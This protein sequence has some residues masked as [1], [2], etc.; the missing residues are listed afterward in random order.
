MNIT[1]I[2][3]QYLENLRLFNLSVA[4]SIREELSGIGSQV[5]IDETLDIAIIYDE[6]RSYLAKVMVTIDI[7]LNRPMAQIVTTSDYGI[8]ILMDI[9]MT[10]D[11]M[12]LYLALAQSTHQLAQAANTYK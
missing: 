7:R 9:P 5:Y 3:N 12:D 2:R 8:D 11:Q 1:Q 4:N 10:S 6:N